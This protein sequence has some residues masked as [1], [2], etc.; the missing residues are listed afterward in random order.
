MEINFSISK[1]LRML[2]VLFFAHHPAI[3]RSSPNRVV[4]LP[5][6]LPIVPKSANGIFTSFFFYEILTKF[7]RILMISIL[8]VVPK[9]VNMIAML[10]F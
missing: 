5:K 9:S 4:V 8:L 7:P 1:R 6:S 2:G 10:E 3:L